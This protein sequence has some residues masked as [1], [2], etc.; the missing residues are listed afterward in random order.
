M[1]AGTRTSTKPIEA[2]VDGP[3]V[4]IGSAVQPIE[5]STRKAVWPPRWPLSASV[6]AIT[7]AKSASTPLVMKVFSP[8]RTQSSPSRTARMRIAVASE[9]AS[10]SV[11]AKQ[12]IRS[13]SIVGSRNSCCCSGDA[14]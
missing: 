5:R 13:P 12:E 14:L 4:S 2:G 1:R 6:T 8:L 10:G 11:I 7:I 3:I 9:P